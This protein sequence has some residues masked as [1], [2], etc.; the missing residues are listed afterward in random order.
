METELDV[1]TYHC[2]SCPAHCELKK[3]GELPPINT[4][5]ETGEILDNYTNTRGWYLVP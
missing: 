1:K 5:I 2:D 4:C 3:E